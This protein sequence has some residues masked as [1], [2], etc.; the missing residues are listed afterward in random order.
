MRRKHCQP[1]GWPRPFFHLHTQE[2]TTEEEEPST[3][4][5]DVTQ[6][7][8]LDNGVDKQEISERKAVLVQN[9]QK[10]V[11]LKQS[12]SFTNLSVAGVSLKRSCSCRQINMEMDNKSVCSLDWESDFDDCFGGVYQIGGETCIE[13]HPQANG[14]TGLTADEKMALA[15][16]EAG[17]AFV[18][19]LLGVP[20]TKITLLPEGQLLGHNRFNHG[21]FSRQYLTSA[22]N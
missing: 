20:V 7:S 17:H 2:E 5:I 6:A 4:E 8:E 18:A 9:V 11:P 1:H 12:K 15:S 22:K 19:F 21:Y 16:H 3:T 13:C 14:K 10:N